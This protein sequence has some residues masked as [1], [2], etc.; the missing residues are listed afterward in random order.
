MGCPHP[1]L[2]GG[3]C[4]GEGELRCVH[5]WH[6]WRGAA[7]GSLRCGVC[8]ARGGLHLGPPP[9]LSAYCHPGPH[10]FLPTIPRT[11]RGDSWLWAPR[12]RAASVLGQLMHGPGVDTASLTSWL[13]GAGPGSHHPPA[14][15]SRGGSARYL[16][17]AET[18][19]CTVG[20]LWGLREPEPQRPSSV[21]GRGKACWL[22]HEPAVGLSV[23][24]HPVHLSLCCLAHMMPCDEDTC[25]HVRIYPYILCI[26]YHTA[27]RSNVSSTTTLSVHIKY[28][29]CIDRL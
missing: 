13:S 14:R 1:G 16:E 21:R 25:R 23:L 17:R 9:L 29:N 5:R 28:C 15:D 2:R 3:S 27:A 24:L 10:L 4:R 19:R 20:L 11:Q 22:H 6:R 18:A 12:P 26:K 8:R 7:D